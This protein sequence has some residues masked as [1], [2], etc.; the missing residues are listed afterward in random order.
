MLNLWN[1]RKTTLA[2]SISIDT[3]A[4]KE[5][6]FKKQNELARKLIAPKIYY[7]FS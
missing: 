4:K 2:A 7:L 1:Q 3:I 6:F 5:F